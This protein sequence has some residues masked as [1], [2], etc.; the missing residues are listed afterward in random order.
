MSCLTFFKF[1]L[2]LSL[3]NAILKQVSCCK[4]LG[5]IIDNNLTWLEHI[6]YIY[7]KIL[8]FTSVFY[9]IRHVLPLKV[10]ITIYFA[11]VHSH[12]LYGIEIYGNT[13]R[14]YIN[15][16][17]VL[18]NKLLRILQNAPRKAPVSDLY[19]N[20]DTLNSGRSVKIYV[21]ISTEFADIQWSTTYMLSA[22]G[23]AAGLFSCD[24]L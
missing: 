24:L 21:T 6:N 13:Y 3:G 19:E 12:L 18:K 20:F 22:R 8:K 23:V 16:L 10:L 7:N 2:T 14:A 9:K 11:F 5:I 4:Y 17:M 1:V 15:R